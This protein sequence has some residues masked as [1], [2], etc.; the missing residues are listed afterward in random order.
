MN[1]MP[2]RFKKWP[3]VSHRKVLK[4]G[5]SYY[6]S[7]PKEFVDRHHINKGDGLSVVA[8]MIMK[9]IPPFKGK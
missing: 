8:D 9:I 5:G 2:T 3:L 6:I 7:L 1:K 4:Q